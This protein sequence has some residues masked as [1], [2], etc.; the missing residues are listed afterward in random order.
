M[1]NWENRLPTSLLFSE[2][3][4]LYL[5]F[6]TLFIRFIVSVYDSKLPFEDLP[7]QVVA[8]EQ[9]TVQAVAAIAT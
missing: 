9:A 5:S 2:S 8:H 7:Q 3:Q 6:A 1:E 4:S